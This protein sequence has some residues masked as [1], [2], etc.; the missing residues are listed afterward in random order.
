MRTQDNVTMKSQIYVRKRTSYNPGKF[1]YIKLEH[2]IR[3]YARYAYC[4][5]SSPL[6]QKTN[7]YDIKSFK[8]WLHTEI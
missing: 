4:C 1:Q 6:K 7:F 3:D 5:G 2:A 8:Q